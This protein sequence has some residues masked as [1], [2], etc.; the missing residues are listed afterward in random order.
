VARV[1]KVGGTKNPR[2][3]RILEL[4]PDLVFM[5]EEENR[6]EDADALR[7]AGVRVHASM[8]RTA[9]ETADMVRSIARAVGRDDRGEEIASDIERRAERVRR[10]AAGRAPVSYAYLIWREPWMSVNDDTFVAGL[11]SLPAGRNVFGG[12]AERYPVIS[13]EDLARADPRLVLLSTEPFPFADRHVEELSAVTHIP[14]D[15]MHIVDGELLSW[16]GSRTP[17]GIDYAERVLQE[18]AG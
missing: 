11:L 16:H 3:Q 9:W 18:G 14:R 17:R 1:E 15:R 5:N 7:A 6:A 10:G 4:A 2:I 12:A 8:P 13:A